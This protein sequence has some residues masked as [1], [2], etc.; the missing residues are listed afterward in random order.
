MRLSPVARCL[1]TI[2]SIE[3]LVLGVEADINYAGFGDDHE[4][5]IDEP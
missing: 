1:V 4:Q 2:G 3:S 5:D